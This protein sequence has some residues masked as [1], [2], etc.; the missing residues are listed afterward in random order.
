MRYF[1]I[2]KVTELVPGERIRGV[3]AVSLTDEVLH[4]HF[5]DL[6][7]MPGMLV[8]EGAAQLGGFLL[9]TTL[10]S[11]P[12]RRAALVQV[13]NAKFH[14][15]AV[16]G[17][18]LSYEVTIDSTMV[19]AGRVKLTA[20]VDERRIATGGLTFMMVAVDSEKIHEQRRY[21]YQL[22]TRTLQP[23]PPIP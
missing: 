14:S 10:T 4:D 17:D 2:D 20:L 9:E 11:S 21:L 8:L 7:V 5:P 12:Q 23:P 18:V 6:P 15:A 3:K 16:P 19:N 22:W 1:L 13:T